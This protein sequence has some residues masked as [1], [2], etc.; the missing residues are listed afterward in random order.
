LALVLASRAPE[1]ILSVWVYCRGRQASGPVREPGALARARW[2]NNVRVGDRL[3]GLARTRTFG[4]VIART[5]FAT[6]ALG[7]AI[8]APGHAAAQKDC[9]LTARIDGVRFQIIVEQ[10]TKNVSCTTAKRT[11]SSYMRTYKQPKGWACF[12]GH[13]SQGQDWA[14][15]C[16]RTRRPSATVRA[17][18]PT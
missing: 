5:L 15:A 13:D 16:S 10:G 6:A 7:L 3:S 17:Y 8:A 14:A 4:A 2:A 12:L 11:L 18:A 1:S 9:G